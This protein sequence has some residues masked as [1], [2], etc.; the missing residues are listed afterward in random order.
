MPASA[1]NDGTSH[2]RR[3]ANARVIAARSNAQIG[4][5]INE[6]VMLRCHVTM[7]SLSL[8]KKSRMTSESGKIAPSI[9]DHVMRRPRFM[10]CA[11]NISSP[12]KTAF[13][14]NAP[15]MPCVIVSIVRVYPMPPGRGIL[16]DEQKRICFGDDFADATG[17]NAMTIES[18]DGGLCGLR[19]DGDQQTAGG[20][21][22]AEK[23]AVFLRNAFGKTHTIAN[24]IAV[25]LQAAREK[26]FACG[27][28]C[29]GKIANGGMIDL[30]GHGFDSAGR[31]TKRHLPSVA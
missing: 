20:L 31:I 15:A 22:V 11:A 18:G 16:T 7:S 24:E 6:C 14:I 10:G 17:R 19:Q 13:P 12:R 5:R 28:Q 26:P 21:R 29:S 2:F 8:E 3:L 4:S 1:T 9:S 30:E 27:L 25:I 23:I